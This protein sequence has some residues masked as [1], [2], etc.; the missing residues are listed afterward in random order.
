[1][2]LNWTVLSAVAEFILMVPG[3][4]IGEKVRAS[5][6]L[7]DG[8]PLDPPSP[9]TV[10]LHK[11]VGYV[12]TSPDDER[13]L[14]PV[15]YSR[16]R[17]FLSA[18]G[19]LDKETSGLLLLTDDGQL[20]HRIKSPSKRIWKV[21]VATLDAPLSA[22]EAAAA[23]RRFASGTLT[24]EGDRSPLLPAALS[25][26]EGGT[27]AEVALAEGRYHQVRRMFAALGRKVVS[28]HRRTVGALTLEGLPEGEWRHVTPTDLELVF[29]GQDLMPA[30]DNSSNGVGE[31][32]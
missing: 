3:R 11:P 22:K 13:V 1:M 7:L 28:L 24:L 5:E 26:L 15:V 23:A 12:V 6:V 9:L 14:D 18:V 17:P 21:Y 30:D 31:D 27:T 32:T 20:L 2:V 19:R 4:W 29:G 8:E 25:V 16:R 10:L